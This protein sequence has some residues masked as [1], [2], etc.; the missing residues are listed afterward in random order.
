[1]LTYNQLFG[2]DESPPASF[3]NLYRLCNQRSFTIHAGEEVLLLIS[4]WGYLVE[5]EA[6]YQLEP[7]RIPWEKTLTALSPDRQLGIL[8]KNVSDKSIH[9]T[10]RYL[11]KALLDHP[12][13]KSILCHISISHNRITTPMEGG[14]LFGKPIVKKRKIF[15]W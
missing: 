11:L 2:K 6:I 3:G 8:M 4:S 9:V 12:Q 10:F 5:N 7:E 1:M 15:P 13:L 14:G